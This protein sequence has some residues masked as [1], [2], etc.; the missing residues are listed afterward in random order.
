[1]QKKLVGLFYKLSLPVE[2]CD[3]KSKKI[4]SGSWFTQILFSKQTDK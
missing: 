3:R 1:M 2:E 4:S